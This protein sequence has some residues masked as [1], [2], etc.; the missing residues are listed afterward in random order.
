MRSREARALTLRDYWRIVTHRWWVV[1]IAMLAAVVPAVALS[2]SQ[3]PIYVAEARMLLQSAPGESLFG[4]DFVY[5]EPERTVA[6]EIEVLEGDVVYQQVIDDLGLATDP[7]AVTGTSE[8]DTDIVSVTVESGDPETA[9]A[10]ANAY[11]NAYKEVK[12]NQ[13]VEGLEEAGQALQAKVTELQ[14]QIDAIDQQIL[15]AS[16]E[17]QALLDV[18]R[19]KLVDTQGVFN[20]RL[21]QVQV[22][23][24]LST[25]SA[26]LVQPAY[27]PDSPVEPT[28]RRTAALALAVGLLLGL[29]AVF[30]LDYLD[31]PKWSQD[32]ARHWGP[33]V[34]LRGG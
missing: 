10:L 7:P 17:E 12:R 34:K 27:A 22:D 32:P 19:R 28:P 1:A 30:L 23:A 24:A 11:V 20:Q 14:D 25:G 26:Q 29:G 15:T 9:A 16:E 18:E 3:E 13:A 5:T 33:W 21:D 6:N 31:D 2:V 8:V 4:N